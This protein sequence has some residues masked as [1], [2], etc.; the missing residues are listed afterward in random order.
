[1]HANQ[2]NSQIASNGPEYFRRA[3]GPSVFD[4]N[5]TKYT[6]ILLNVLYTKSC[7]QGTHH[8]QVTAAPPR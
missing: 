3:I 1:M 8:H 5:I 7:A 2:L 6:Q 4:V